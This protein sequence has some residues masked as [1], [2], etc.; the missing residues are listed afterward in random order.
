MLK[1]MPWTGGAVC[2]GLMIL[3]GLPPGGIF[4]SEYRAFSRRLC[5]RSMP[6]L[7]GAAL[8]LLAIVFVSFISHLNRMLYGTPSAEAASARWNASTGGIALLLLSVA[9]AGHARADHAGAAGGAARTQSRVQISRLIRV[10]AH[11]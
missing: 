9:A 1:T 5:C 6:W 10:I 3:I 7:M 4:V 11:D 8:V 2:R